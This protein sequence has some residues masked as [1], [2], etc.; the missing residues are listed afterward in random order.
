MLLERAGRARY[1]LVVIDAFNS[2][3]VPVH[4][5]TREAVTMYMSR[6]RPGG[7][8]GLH[9]SNRFVDLEAPLG[10]VAR[11]TGLHCRYVLDSPFDRSDR[12]VRGKSYSEWVVLARTRAD[13]GSFARW[14]PCA[15]DPAART[16]T[17]DYVNL[18]DAVRRNLL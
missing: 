13:L 8:L 9:I 12:Q 15:T 18:W 14:S 4:L 2:D 7:L 10:N 5:L 6:L 17:D 3:A 1:D 11:A 16:W